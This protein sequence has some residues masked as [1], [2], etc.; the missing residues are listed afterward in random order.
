VVLLLYDAHAG[1]LLGFCGLGTPRSVFKILNL[2]NN[3]SVSL[4]FILFFYFFYFVL[5]FFLVG[6]T[7][8]CTPFL[9]QT[10]GQMDI[11]VTGGHA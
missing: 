5:I 9:I 2:P 4:D 11:H 6:C 8:F 7:S 10:D 3:C 1:L